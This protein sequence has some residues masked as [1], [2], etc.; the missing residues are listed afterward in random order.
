MSRPERIRT[1]QSVALPRDFIVTGHET[2]LIEVAVHHRLADIANE[3]REFEANAA[4]TFYQTYAWCSAWIESSDEPSEPR[5][6]IG[7]DRSGVI[8]FLLPFCIRRIQGIAILEWIAMPQTTYGYGLYDREFLP[9]AKAWFSLRGWEIARMLGKV[10]A[11]NLAEMPETLH[12]F[13]HPLSDWFS[14][15]GPNR[16]YQILLESDF[17]GL[18]ERKRSSATRRSNRK[19]DGKLAA[20]GELNFV[21]P[22]TRSQNHS[23]IDEMFRQQQCRLSAR[24]IHGV[25]DAHDRRFIH[26]LADIEANSG[27]ALLPYNLTIDQHMVAM[28][29]G[30]FYGNIYWGLISSLDSD[31]APHLSPGDAALRRLIAAC[32][33]KRMAVLDLASGDAPYKAQWADVVIPLHACIRGLTPRGYIWAGLAMLRVIVKRTI[34]RSPRLWELAQHLRRTV[35]HLRFRPVTETSLGCLVGLNMPGIA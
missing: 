5:I 6:I 15:E 28:K 10:D 25:F 7:R 18:Y 2:S 30:G 35:A 1:D 12:G 33:E 21:L 9:R 13:P 8:R 17:K 16:G 34:K 27:P 32:C 20:L 19:R 31:F 23:R 4:G 14:C 26:R 22:E 29:L 24:G 11:L 3:W